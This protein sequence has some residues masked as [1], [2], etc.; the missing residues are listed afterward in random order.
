MPPDADR[1]RSELVRSLWWV[2]GAMA[3][4]E[5]EEWNI[6]EWFERN[7]T[8]DTGMAD[9]AVWLGLVII[10]LLITGWIALATRFRS[11][12][13]VAIVALPPVGLVAMGN[14]F[15]HLTWTLLFSDYAPGV[16]TAV[17]FVMPTSAIALWRMFRVSRA[18]A[19]PIAACAA[20]WGVA[21]VQVVQGG[22]ELQPFQ[23][24]LQASFT[25]LAGALGLIGPGS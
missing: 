2:A 14:A 4:H 16:V 5:L 13:V 21:A 17:L 20:L 23:Q 6:D 1:R 12:A 7:F 8:N 15:Q 11:A 25:S 9:E 19:V 10:I 18:F 3:L 22:R 24:V